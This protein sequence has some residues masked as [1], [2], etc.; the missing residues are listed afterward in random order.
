MTYTRTSLSA[1]AVALAAA[2]VACDAAPLPDA[3]DA[4]VDASTA[5]D[6][7]SPVDAAAADAGGLKVCTPASAFTGCAEGQYCE[8]TARV[9]VE[10]VGAKS[11][12]GDDG[13]REVCDK[14]EV[15]AAGRLVS[16]GF[17]RPAPCQGGA[18]CVPEGTTRASCEEVVCEAGYRTCQG[19]HVLTCNAYGT[20]AAS[21]VCGAGKACYQGACENIRHNVLL[22]FDTSG[23]MSDFID[24]S[25]TDYPI[26]CAAREQGDDRPCFEAFPACEDPAAPFT[27]I[28]LAKRVFAETVRDV[29]GGY[30]QFALQRFPQIDVG[31]NVPSCTWG[32]Y[33]GAERMTGDDD[34]RDTTLS[35]WFDAGLDEAI[36]VPFPSRSSLSNEDDLLEWLD[37]SERL[38]A[39]DQPCVSHSD[40]DASAG[41][42]GRYNGQRRCFYHANDELRAAGETPLGKSLF[43]AGEYFRRRVVVDGKPCSSD[44]SCGSVGYRCHQG[45][46]VDP[47]RRCRD[48]YIIVF[49]DGEESVNKEET[50]FFNPVVQ[51]RRL[52]FG[53]DCDTADDCRGGATCDEGM[54]LPAAGRLLPRVPSMDTGGF[55]ALSS[56]DGRPISVKTTVITLEGG[57]ASHKNLRIAAAGGGTHADATAD[58]AEDFKIKLKTAM[59]SALKC[60]PE[61]IED[62]ALPGTSN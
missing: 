15:D 31:S 4:G 9:C 24:P 41:R 3:P 39:T 43:Y 25:Y 13:D 10:C 11:R 53:L 32:W 8:T 49:T 36:V 23:S 52:A 60:T 46:C 22:V 40:C 62:I 34:A 29:I 44:A 1:A 2:L 17:W 50:D 42:C 19:S 59:T 6:T 27:L 45:A 48:N 16:G 7:V 47:Y 38:G 58:A 51:A 54:C 28:G 55:G 14:P 5:A 33:R 21:T 35:T 61:D 56:P 12:C 57:A 18:V 20:E 37:F 26:P 30:S